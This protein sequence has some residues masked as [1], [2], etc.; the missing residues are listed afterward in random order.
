MNAPILLV[1]VGDDIRK[2]P[3]E[4]KIRVGTPWVLNRTAMD[5]GPY[6]L[7]FAT[8]TEVCF[9]L[10]YSRTAENHVLVLYAFA[11]GNATTVRLMKF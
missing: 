4:Q 10:R 6:S 1:I 7:G 9:A 3:L 8:M 11:S 5:R 2:V